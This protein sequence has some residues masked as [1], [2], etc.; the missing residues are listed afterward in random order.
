MPANYKRCSLVRDL[1]ILKAPTVTHALGRSSQD[2]ILEFINL[3]F[4]TIRIC[5][6]GARVLV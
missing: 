1:S 4:A 6:G 2:I 5:G 3:R